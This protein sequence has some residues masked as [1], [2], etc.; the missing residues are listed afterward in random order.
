MPLCLLVPSLPRSPPLITSSTDYGPSLRPVK[1]IP[2]PS[3]P[4]CSAT[5][6]TALH[7][8]PRQAGATMCAC[9]KPKPSFPS[10]AQIPAS[11][12][13]FSPSNFVVFTMKIL[14]SFSLFFAALAP[15]AQAAPASVD[16]STSL[17]PVSMSWFAGYHTDDYPISK[18]KWHKYTH[19][20]YTFACAS[21]C[22][23]IS[24]CALMHI[25]P[26]R[27]DGERRSHGQWLKCRSAAR[28]CCRCSQGCEC[29]YRILPSEL[30]ADDRDICRA[31][32]RLQRLAAG[33]VACTIL[34]TSPPRKIALRLLRQCSISRMITCLTASISRAFLLSSFLLSLTATIAGSTRPARVSAATPYLQT[35]RTTSLRSSRSCAPLRPKNL[36][37]PPRVR[38]SPGST[39]P[40]SSRQT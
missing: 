32:K 25:C 7:R 21:I 20:S 34:Q 39:P 35:I 10:S 2:D 5:P 3:S 13:T 23:I 19:V 12:H 11:T 37:S 28:F 4:V 29:L 40:A 30:H 38:F 36:S 18:V 9:Y 24:C 8:T 27:D 26:Q 33:A 6:R 16:I 1:N 15:L 14:H 22:Q 31:S 17:S